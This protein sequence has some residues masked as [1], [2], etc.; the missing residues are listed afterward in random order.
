M[1]EPL[2]SI[3]TFSMFVEGLDHPEG[4]AWGRDGN[5]YAGGEAGQIYRIA[6]D[7][8]S[9]TEMA[10]TGGFILG[11]CMDA[12]NTIYACDLGHQAV[13]RI[14]QDGDISTYSTG[15]PDR[16]LSHRTIPYLM[17]AATSTSPVRVHSANTQAACSWCVPAARRGDQYR[18][19]AFSQTA[20][21]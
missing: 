6:P 15:A 1:P 8:S 21:R 9:V 18:A 10:S 5:L 4:I 13:M 16:P 2:L 14:T 3:D 11:L 20:W 19:D 17:I 12:N 7:G